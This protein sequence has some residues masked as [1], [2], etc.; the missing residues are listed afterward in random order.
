MRPASA[1]RRALVC[2]VCLFFSAAAFA[3]RPQPTRIE[4]LRLG[5]NGVY[6]VG[7]WTSLEA[8][9]RGGDEPADG[10]LQVSTADSDGVPVTYTA[11]RPVRVVPGQ[12]ASVRLY[13]RP[14]QTGGE[15]S[16]RLVDADGK[17]RAKSTFYADEGAGESNVPPALPAVDRIVVAFGPPVGLS[18]SVQQS[19]SADATARTAVAQLE[20]PGQLPLDWYGYEG[21]ETVIL[22]TSEPESYRGL[23]ADSQRIAA[24]ERWVELGGHLVIF[25]GREAPEFLGPDG[26]LARLAPGKYVESAPLRNSSPLE[27]FAAAEEPIGRGRI[28]LRVPKLENVEGQI[29]SHAGRNPEDLPLIVRTRRQLGQITF[30]A[31]DPDRPPLSDWSGRDGLLQKILGWPRNNVENQTA[32]NNMLTGQRF[33]DLSGQLRTALDVQFA[34]IKPAPF[35]LVA[36][37]IIAYIALIGPGDYFFVKRVLKRMELTWI[38]FPLCVAG[39]SIGAYFLA[40]AL[41]GDQLRVNQVELVDVDLDS[42]L[43]RGTVWTHYFSPSVRQYNLTIHP[44]FAATDLEPAEPPL[45]AWLGMPGTGLGGMQSSA[46]QSIL[47]GRGYQI[48]PTLDAIAGMPVQEWSTKTLTARW[49]AEVDPPLK[50]SLR[51]DGDELVTGQVTNQTDVDLQE[52]VLLFGRWAYQVRRLSAGETIEINQSLQPRTVKTQ[53]TGVE[54]R[55]DENSPP[56]TEAPVMFDPSGADID[57][58][59][60]LMMFYEALGGQSYASTWHRYQH[61]VDM[62]RLLRSDSAILLARVRSVTGSQWKDGDD[63]LK[64]DSDRH[65]TYYRFLIPV[66]APVQIT[67]PQP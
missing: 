8:T 13:V 19:S 57:R 62:S 54:I 26:A 63:P 25:C 47:P 15:F 42:G 21:I 56:V 10:F 37:L 49:T 64:S 7:C 35:A 30:A 67:V 29:L 14:G 41:K 20:D 33:E 46:A 17:L 1:L 31:F 53:L 65:W 55:D 23:T 4:S 45:I 12:T 48:V 18:K 3:Q 34:G 27:L 16:V 24:L 50:A 36:I 11:P 66:K 44:R 40:F 61:F 59:A 39:V 38:T 2:C 6:K 60:K 22:A 58:L 52:C 43:A 9:L 28:D 51:P 5:F 32:E